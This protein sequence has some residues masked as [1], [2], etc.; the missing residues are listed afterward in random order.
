MEVG[1][2]AKRGSERS[3]EVATTVA[4]ALTEEGC[5]VVAEETVAARI[6]GRTVDAIPA[7]HLA[8]CDLVVSIGGDGTF[9]HATH[10]VD[11]TPILG[12]N[13][14]EVGFLNPVPPEDAERAVLA[15]VATAREGEGL[16]VRE[17]MRLTAS[18]PDWTLPPALNEVV[19]TGDRRGPGG[20]VDLAVAVDDATYTEGWAD[21]VLVATPTGSTAYNLSE[22]GPLVHPGVAAMVITEMAATD[23]MPPLIVGPDHE[24][25]VTV[26]AAGTETAVVAVDGGHRQRVALPAD[27]TVRRADQPTRIAGPETDF[28]TALDKLD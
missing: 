11:R 1:I 27:V 22:G 12:V 19:V 8:D 6:D 17:A 13:L 21:G 24:V 2:V 10:H 3:T 14:G 9:L 28:F 15:A 4:A 16:P 5:R 7:D 25:T 26:R 20:G 18:G 23:P